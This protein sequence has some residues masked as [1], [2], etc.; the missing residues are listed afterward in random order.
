MINK[1]KVKDDQ[2]ADAIAALDEQVKRK[3]ESVEELSEAW[4]DQVEQLQ[5]VLS[6]QNDLIDQMEED[7][8]LNEE[9]ARLINE[10]IAAHDKY[11]DILHR[12][13]VAEEAARLQHPSFGV[14]E[15]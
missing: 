5:A 2:L 10:G 11:A 14:G 1:V 8:R 15:D 6:Q 4:K 3:T 13:A 9:R 12:V 7:N